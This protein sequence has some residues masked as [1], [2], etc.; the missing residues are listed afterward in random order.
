MHSHSSLLITFQHFFF[1]F[2]CLQFTE[3]IYDTST[4]SIMSYCLPCYVVPEIVV[5]ESLSPAAKDAVN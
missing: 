3:I 4:F 2:I 5:A 1:T